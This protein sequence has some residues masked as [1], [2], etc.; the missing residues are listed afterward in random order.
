MLYK[1]QYFV[2]LVL[3]KLDEVE[4]QAIRSV[5]GPIKVPVLWFSVEKQPGPGER[6]GLGSTGF[7]VSVSGKTIVNLGDSILLDDWAGLQPDV[8]ML[9]IGGM[10]NDTWTMDVDDAVKAVKIIAPKCVIPCHYN[11]PFLWIKNIAKADDQRFKN[12][13][14]SLGIDCHILQSG[15]ELVI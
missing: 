4:I 12:E 11:V 9:P 2:S 1:E 10:G 14:N 7:K 3:L 13:V 6:V 8:L 15:E 5:H